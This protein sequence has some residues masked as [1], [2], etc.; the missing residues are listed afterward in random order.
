MVGIGGVLAEALADVAFRLVPITAVDADGDAR[1]PRTAR[2]CSARSAASRRSTATPLADVLLGAVASRGRARPDVA[3]VDVNP[4]IV[5]R[6]PSR[7]RST[8][9]SEVRRVARAGPRRRRHGFER[10]SSRA[11]SWSPG[12]SAHPGQVRLRRAAQH[13]HAGLRAARSTAPTSRAVRCSASPTCHA[14][15]TSCPTARPSISSSCARRPRP[16]RACSR[17]RAAR[18]I[19]AAFITSAGYGEAGDEGRRAE[20]DLVALADELGCCS[21]DPNGQG[22]VSTPRQL[23]RADRGAVPAARVG[24]RSRASRATS[25]RRSM[26]Y[27][28][29]DRRRREPRGV[30]RA[31]RP[32]S[33]VADYLEYFADDPETRGRLAYV[34]GDRRRPGLLRAVARSRPTKPLVLL[35]GGRPTGGQRAAA[36]HTGALAS[37]DRVFDGMCR[38]A[39]DHA[40]RRRRG[41][42]RCRGHVRHAAA[43][44][45]AAGGGAHD[46]RRLGRRDRR[47]DRPI[48]A[49]ARS[50]SPT[51]CAPRSTRSCRRAGAG[52]TRS[53]SPAARPATRS[54]RCWSSSPRHPDVDAVVYL[55]IGIQSNQARA[56]ARRA[57][58]SRP[59]PRADRRVPRAPGRAVRRGRGRRLGPRRA[60]RSSPRPSSRS[61]DPENAGPRAVRDTGRFCFPSAHRAVR[62]LEHLWRHAR[63]AARLTITCTTPGTFVRRLLVGVLATAAIVVS[64]CARSGSA[65]SDESVDAPALRRRCGRPGASRSRSSTRSARTACRRARR[66][67]SPGSTRASSSNRGRT[68][69]LATH[70]DARARPASTQKLLTAAAALGRARPRRHVHDTA[71]APA[72]AAGRGDREPVSRRRRRPLLSTADSRRY[73]RAIPELRARRRRRSS[74]SPTR[75]SRRRRQ[76]RRRHRSRRLAP[77]GRALP[78]AWAPTT[79]PRA[80]RAAGR[81]HRERRFGRLQR[82]AASPSTTPR[83]LAAEILAACSRSGA[84]TSGR[85][86]RTRTAPEGAARSPR[87]ARPPFTEIVGGS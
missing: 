47:R 6:R 76:R 42:V 15:S 59:G 81:A 26:N 69:R 38:Q 55:G 78:P 17:S 77:R 84:S 51:T 64:S 80:G 16:T 31:T 12:A 48:G 63:H 5:V 67:R 24:S 22:L 34:E 41:G 18:G 62:A 43:A 14:R 4:L 52:T 56:D 85:R 75:S 9:S 44:R 37:D 25:C 29:A 27:A 58:L 3:R 70:A 71:L 57:L 53:T 49:R 83:V 86:R 30:G 82:A 33:R 7:S 45:G 72:A 60:S 79:A 1:R 10:C 61:R 35:K 32:R 54:P 23:V 39:G 68:R 74:R 46:R 11:A 8:P 87:S 36:S 19:R 65:D 13:P 50:R 40:R 66:R 21:P 28:G 2:R 20:A 73:S